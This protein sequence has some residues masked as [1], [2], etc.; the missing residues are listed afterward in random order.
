MKHYTEK[1]W[2]EMASRSP[3]FF[4]KWEPTPFNIDRV[5]AGEL[6]ASYIG[7]RNMI[8]FEEGHGTVLMTEGVH[9][10]IGDAS[11]KR[12]LIIAEWIPHREAYRLYRPVKCNDTVAYVNSLHEVDYE[13]Y[14]VKIE[15]ER[16]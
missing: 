2:N 10:T 12:E 4:G 1:E 7:K 5:E 9:F 11:D 3:S 16:K 13:K 15:G 8:T 14:A 6:P